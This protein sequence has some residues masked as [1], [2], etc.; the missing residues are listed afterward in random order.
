MSFQMAIKADV[1]GDKRKMSKY[2]I[3][4]IRWSRDGK[5]V[6]SKPC[7]NCQRALLGVGINNIIFSTEDGRFI[8]DKLSNLVCKPSS[9]GTYK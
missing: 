2:T 9:G 5:V 7:I 3:W 6:C 1:C 4:D 8:K